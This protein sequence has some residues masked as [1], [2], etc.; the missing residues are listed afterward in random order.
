MSFQI[1]VYAHIWSTYNG[2]LI[3]LCPYMNIYKGF[4]FAC[5]S[6][7][8]FKWND[9]VVHQTFICYGE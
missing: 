6:A 4:L 5:F 8:T 9:L 7:K 2:Q 3:V 1:I